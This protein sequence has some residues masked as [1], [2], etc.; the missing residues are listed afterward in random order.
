[1]FRKSTNPETFFLRLS[2]RASEKKGLGPKVAETACRF[3]RELPSGPE[4][5]FVPEVRLKTDKRTAG[6]FC[7][8]RQNPK[9]MGCKTRSSDRELQPARITVT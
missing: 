9:A 1:M 4:R 5:H 7:C 8:N 2:H 3:L 6:R